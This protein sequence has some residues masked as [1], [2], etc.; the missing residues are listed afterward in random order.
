MIYRSLDWLFDRP[1]MWA[2]RD[3]WFCDLK[4]S[5]VCSGLISLRPSMSDFEGM[6]DYAKTLKDLPH[7]DQRLI[8]MYFQHKRKEPVQLLSD[9]EAQFGQCLGK[10]MTPY[11]NHDGTRV[12]GV[13][14]TPSF[15]HKSGG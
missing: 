14:N 6:L 11:R 15:L 3:D 5:E 8:E 12:W 7:G 9:V 10:A 1:G 4:R 2:Q 13:W